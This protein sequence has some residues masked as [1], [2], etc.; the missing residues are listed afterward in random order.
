MHCKRKAIL[1]SF[2]TQHS[3]VSICGHGQMDTYCDEGHCSEIQANRPSESNRR[4]DYKVIYSRTRVER[5]TY[6]HF[7]EVL[8]G[9]SF[10]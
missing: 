9:H 4:L 3:R 10:R 6:T 2:L 1:Y 8:L 5:T 7:E